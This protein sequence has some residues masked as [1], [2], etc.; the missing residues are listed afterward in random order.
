MNVMGGV[1]FTYVKQLE[2]RRGAV[3]KAS[4]LGE[5]EAGKAWLEDR[6]V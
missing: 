1:I 5:V 4:R 6:T 3:R 2:K